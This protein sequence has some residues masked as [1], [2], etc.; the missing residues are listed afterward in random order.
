MAPCRQPSSP[1]AFVDTFCL[2][3]SLTT[4]PSP[5]FPPRPSSPGQPPSDLLALTRRPPRP[6]HPA[7]PRQQQQRE[8][9]LRGPL[10]RVHLQPLSPPP[11]PP[12]S[13]DTLIV[14]KQYFSSDRPQPWP[15]SEDV[16]ASKDRIPLRLGEREGCRPRQRR[17]RCRRC[18]CGT[19]PPQQRNTPLRPPLVQQLQLLR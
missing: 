5:T 12:P 10:A 19:R 11:P 18:P 2:H 6:R 4:S 8:R 16:S 14:L 7:R 1:S 15:P 17:R 3:S 9:P 13:Q